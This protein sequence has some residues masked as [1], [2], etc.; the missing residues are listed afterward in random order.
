[1]VQLENFKGWVES[2]EIVNLKIIFIR[3]ILIKNLFPWL[4]YVQLFTP[5]KKDSHHFSLLFN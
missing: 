5:N 1:M 2:L 3:E 4:I